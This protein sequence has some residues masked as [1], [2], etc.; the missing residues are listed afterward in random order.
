MKHLLGPEKYARVAP[1]FGSI[2]YHLAVQ[3]VLSGAIPGSVW[4]D[5]DEHPRAALVRALHRFHLGGDPNISAFNAALNELF[6]NEIYPQGLKSGDTAFGLYYSAGWQ[7]SIEG[8]I[9]VGLDPIPGQRQYYEFRKMKADWRTMVPP[10]LQMAE[11]DRALAEDRSLTN[12]D[13]LVEEMLSERESVES[14]LA[15]S[16]GCCLRSVD[17]L[18]TWCLSEYN[19][20]ERCEV[21]IA[22]DPA[23]RKRGLASATGSAFVEMA[24]ARGVRRIGWHCWASNSGSW[25]T[26]LKI[27]YE[28][29]ADYSSYLAFFQRAFS[30]AVNGDMLLDKGE[31]MQAAGWLAR[32]IATGEAPIWAYV[33]AARAAVRLGE[34]ANALDLLDQAVSR[35]YKVKQYLEENEDLAPLRETWQWTSLMDRLIG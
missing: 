6:V 1:L 11:V 25:A 28:K 19:L 31:Y 34:E 24:L 23:Y 17:K 22:T 10:D 8:Q 26:A 27:G 14:F 30:L 32:S 7:P 29:V 12:L 2:D 35:G 15:H 16:F 13:W 20:G 21:G 3:A 18:V 33:A 5:N 9:L 4:V